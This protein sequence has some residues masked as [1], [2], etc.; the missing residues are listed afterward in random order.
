MI[1]IEPWL[2]TDAP[3]DVAESLRAARA[4]APRRVAVERCVALVAASS[5]VG[6]STSL[7][8]AASYGAGGKAAGLVAL[9]KWG[10]SGVPM[11]TALVT[12]DE[13]N[14][15]AHPLRQDERWNLCVECE[16][17]NHQ[18]QEEFGFHLATRMQTRT[19]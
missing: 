7:A 4:E 10:L 2:L 19:N 17:Q 5:A 6:L 13:V 8:S 16:R 1:D 14:V 18:R 12:G 9:V 11:G 3:H 15:H